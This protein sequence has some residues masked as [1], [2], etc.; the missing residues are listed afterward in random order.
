M[1]GRANPGD[2]KVFCRGKHGLHMARHFDFTPNLPN[3]ALG[4]D[5][6]RRPVHS[7]VFAA[8]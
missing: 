4:V 1:A 5:Q 8:V 3:D 6:E 7:H 2:S